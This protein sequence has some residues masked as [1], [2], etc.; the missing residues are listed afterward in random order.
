MTKKASS[1]IQLL[2]LVWA[3]CNQATAHS[4]ERLNHSMR[5]ALSLAIGAGFTF[6]PGDMAHVFANYRSGYWLSDSDEWIYS[7]AIGVENSTAYQSYEAAKEREP[8]LADD[9]RFSCH[10]GYTHGSSVNRTRERLSVGAEFDW[11]GQKLTVT[12]FA[13][14]Q[15]YV[16]ACSYKG[17]QYPRK[18]DK[19]FKITRADLLAE[20]KERKERGELM[21]RLTAAAEAPGM[22]EQITKALGV[23]SHSDYARLPI[24]KIRKV[25]AKFIQAEAA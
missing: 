24:D 15:S 12:S 21:K 7:L 19:R 10:G 16:N 23:K 25:A 18:I 14:D 3:N 13:A 5:D 20:R 22:A 9:V 6:A 4:W 2:D 1:A 11:K 8:F 17:Q